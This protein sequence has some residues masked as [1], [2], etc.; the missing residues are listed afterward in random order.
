MLAISIACEWM[1]IAIGVNSCTVVIPF[2]ILNFG[3]N[4]LEWVSAKTIFDVI[5]GSSDMF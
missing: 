2:I 1:L 4:S 5:C 3:V